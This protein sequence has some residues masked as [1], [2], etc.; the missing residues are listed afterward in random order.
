MHVMSTD[1][2]FNL[3]SF[4]WLCVRERGAYGPYRCMYCKLTWS[5]WVPQV[6]FDVE[7]A[8]VLQKRSGPARLDHLWSCCGSSNCIPSSCWRCPFCSRRSSILVCFSCMYVSVFN[9]VCAVIILT[10]HQLEVTL[11]KLMPIDR[12]YVRRLS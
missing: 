3:W 4:C 1:I 5:R 8:K 2:R 7:M 9:I 6:P 11:V 12:R 10:G